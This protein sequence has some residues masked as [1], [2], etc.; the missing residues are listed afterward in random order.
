MIR[1]FRFL[2]GWL[3][4][5]LAFWFVAL[6]LVHGALSGGGIIEVDGPLTIGPIMLLGPHWLFT[7]VNACLAGFFWWIGKAVKDGDWSA[8]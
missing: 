2:A 7:G 6:A 4:L 3:S 8:R 5:I 1:F